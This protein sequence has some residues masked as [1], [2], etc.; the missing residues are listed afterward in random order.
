M[1]RLKI[2]KQQGEYRSFKTGEK[3]IL[4]NVNGA[5]ILE[6][7]KKKNNEKNNL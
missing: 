2:W 4:V 3:M 6:P 5:T 7:L 1:N